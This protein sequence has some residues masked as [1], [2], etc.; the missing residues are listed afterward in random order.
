MYPKSAT[1]YNNEHFPQQFYLDIKLEIGLEIGTILIHPQLKNE[2]HYFASC[3]QLKITELQKSNL[4]GISES[5][6][7]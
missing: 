1:V 5:I 7:K 6:S 2:Y 3:T 4:Q